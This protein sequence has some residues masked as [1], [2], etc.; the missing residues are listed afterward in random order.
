MAMSK[1][2]SETLGSCSSYCCSGFV[3]VVCMCSIQIISEG[4]EPMNFFW[5][6]IGGRKKYDLHAE[7]MRYARLFRC[8]NEKGKL[9]GEGLLF[10]SST[11]YSG[12]G[13]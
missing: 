7:Y 8:S 5:V 11:S 4:E 3:V 1:L 6:G 9:T 13:I 2:M 12:Q 10:L